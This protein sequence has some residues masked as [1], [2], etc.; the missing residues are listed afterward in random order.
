[1]RRK[2]EKDEKRSKQIGIKVQIKTRQQLEYIADREQCT[3]STLIDNIIK[4]YI[5]TYFRIGKIDWEKIPP[6]ERGGK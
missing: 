3:L 2:M 5:K 1:M 4:D 6:E